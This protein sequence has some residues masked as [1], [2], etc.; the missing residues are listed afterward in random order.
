[1]ERYQPVMRGERLKLVLRGGESNA[2]RLRHLCRDGGIETLRSIEARS[3]CCAALRQFLHIVQHRTFDAVFRG[4]QL[5][6]I[7]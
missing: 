4:D 5:G 1:M 3:H 7:S 6:D 2:R